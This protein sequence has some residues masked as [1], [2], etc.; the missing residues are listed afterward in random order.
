MNYS[1]ADFKREYDRELVFAANGNIVAPDLNGRLRDTA[2]AYGYRTHL[3]GMY[4]CYSCG[5]LCECSEL[6]GDPDDT[7]NLI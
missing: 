3:T 7:N 2:G 5:H 1:V 6:Y 4:V